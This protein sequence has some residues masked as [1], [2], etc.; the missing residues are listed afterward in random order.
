M[1]NCVRY[2]LDCRNVFVVYYNWWDNHCPLLYSV[3]ECYE[4]YTINLRDGSVEYSC[5]PIF[6]ESE[7]V[8]DSLDDFFCKVI[9]GD[10]YFGFQSYFDENGNFISL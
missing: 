2:A 5:E 10:I 7:K 9:N 8:A 6:E 4:F 3:I 1:T